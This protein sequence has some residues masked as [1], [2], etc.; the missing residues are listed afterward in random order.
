VI[1]IIRG[2]SIR[3]SINGGA[4]WTNVT[5]AIPISLGAPTY[6]TINPTNSNH[7]WVTLSGYAGGNKVYETVN[8]GTSWTN[9]TAN[10]PNLPV[11]CLIYQVGSN[12]RLYVGMDVG[13]YY[14]DGSSNSWTLYNSGLPN[15]PVK[16]LAI[17]P[18][19]PTK[20]RAATYGRGVYEVDVLQPS[21]APISDFTFSGTICP[22]SQLQ[23]SNTSYGTPTSWS[24]SVA[25]LG[26]VVITSST[27]Q[28]PAI[29]FPAPGSYTV[30]LTASNSSG[31]GSPA[32]KVLSVS[33]GPSL[34]VSIASY[35]VCKDEPVGLSISGAESYTWL[36]DNNN[37]STRFFV[38]ALPAY[39]Y[40]I[41]STAPN[42]CTSNDTLGIYVS[43]CTS[44]KNISFPLASLDV[45]PNPTN[46]KINIRMQLL[47]NMEI[48][49]EVLDATGK[50]AL[51]E[52]RSFKK[53][54]NEHAIVL[55]SLADGSYFLKII[56]DEGATQTV[57]F[58]KE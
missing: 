38:A 33:P 35:T 28:N 45:F 5:G 3:K 44:L 21:T 18:A 23:F 12:D 55:S 56:P 29:S 30:T 19:A 26:G 8:G 50:K 47:K 53:G 57:R 48:A 40:T 27:S 58:M 31:P 4:T 25:P 9:I 46:H 6:I 16:E 7:A 22:N 15:V 49:F 17:S 34:T 36:P 54:L 52:K 24:W 39:H 43:D 11:N 13:V 42:G 20:L 14:K 10:L 32:V 51:S 41:V 37:D 2:T 1:Y